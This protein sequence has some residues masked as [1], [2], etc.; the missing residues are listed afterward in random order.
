MI[1][2]GFMLRNFLS[3]I[4]DAGAII[5]CLIAVGLAAFIFSVLIFAENMRDRAVEKFGT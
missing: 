4:L 3:K 5:I 2:D 1:M